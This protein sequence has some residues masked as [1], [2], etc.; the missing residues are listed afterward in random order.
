MSFAG[1]RKS[2]DLFARIQNSA[3]SR[4]LSR[5]IS[6]TATL[7]SPAS[8]NDNSGDDCPD[9]GRDT[10][11]YC[12]HY[13]R[14]GT[15]AY[16]QQG[17]RSSHN[18]PQPD[19]FMLWRKLGFS[20]IPGWVR[21]RSSQEQTHI[22][23]LRRLTSRGNPLPE[24]GKK[25]YCSFYLQ[26][27]HC[28]YERQ[29]CKFSHQVPDQ[30]DL[31]LWQAIGFTRIPGWLRSGV[32]ERWD[33]RSAGRV[34]GNNDGWGERQPPRGPGSQQMDIS[35]PPMRRTSHK[36]N[37]YEPSKQDEF[38][39]DTALDSFRLGEQT[40]IAK[41]SGVSSK[42]RL[43]ARFVA[44]GLSGEIRYIEEKKPPP[45]I[46]GVYIYDGGC[47]QHLGT[48]VPHSSRSLA[49][50]TAA[51]EALRNPLLDVA[52]L[53]KATFDGEFTFKGGVSCLSLADEHDVDASNCSAKQ[54]TLKGEYTVLRAPSDDRKD[55]CGINVRGLASKVL[56]AD[57]P[58][59][60][61][62]Q[63]SNQPPEVIVSTE[64]TKPKTPEVGDLPKAAGF[65]YLAALYP[66]EECMLT[67]GQR[68]T[69]TLSP[70]DGKRTSNT[71][72]SDLTT[73]S[74]SSQLRKKC[75]F[76]KKP[77]SN[78]QSLIPCTTCPRKYHN[79][80]G[81]P[82]P[83]KAAKGSFVC[84]RCIEKQEARTGN[85]GV[86]APSITAHSENTRPNASAT[87]FD[88]STVQQSP[89]S[90]PQFVGIPREG[91]AANIFND[92]ESTKLKTQ[93]TRTDPLATSNVLVMHD[94][95][96]FDG[97][98]ESVE[99]TKQ[100]GPVHVSSASVSKSSGDYRPGSA[101]STGHFNEATIQHALRRD[102]YD[103]QVRK[104]PCS[105][106]SACSTDAQKGLDELAD[107]AQG[108]RPASIDA[109]DMYG[110]R[111]EENGLGQYLCDD[112]M[113]NV[114]DAPRA[115]KAMRDPGP[116]TRNDTDVGEFHDQ[117]M[118]DNDKENM[119]VPASRHGGSTE[120]AAS[121][122]TYN[123]SIF[124]A[125]QK[126][127]RQY[128][129]VTCPWWQAGDTCKRPEDE[130]IFSHRRTGIESPNGNNKAKHWTCPAW[131]SGEGCPWNAEQCL[132]THADTGYYVGLD[133][134]ARKK[135]LTCYWFYHRGWC[136]RR[137]E[138]CLF[139]HRWTGLLAEEP[140]SRPAKIP[141]RRHECSDSWTPA[142]GTFSMPQAATSTAHDNALHWPTQVQSLI[143]MDTLAPTEFSESNS[144]G[145][146]Q[147]TIPTT[148]ETDGMNAQLWTPET[149][150][151]PQA[152]VDPRA[153]NK[154]QTSAYPQR[155]VE[156]EHVALSA[157]NNL[158]IPV[159][160]STS[161]IPI[162][163]PK[164][165]EL[166]PLTSSGVKKCT[167]CGKKVIGR[168][169][170]V[171]CQQPDRG[172]GDESPSITTTRPTNSNRAQIE[173]P[174]LLPDIDIDIQE[175]SGGIE[176]KDVDQVP[177]T[178]S[179]VLKRSASGSGL[180][181]P[182][183]RT[184][185]NVPTVQRKITT[186]NTVPTSIEEVIAAER[187]KKEHHS[188][189]NSMPITSKR[190]S[191]SSGLA[192]PDHAL[193][194]PVK[195]V[196]A[197]ATRSPTFSNT[198]ICTEELAG[199]QV[200]DK[201]RAPPVEETELNSSEIQQSPPFEPHNGDDEDLVEDIEYSVTESMAEE[202][203][204]TGITANCLEGDSSDEESEIPLLQRY[205][206][207]RQIEGTTTGQE[208]LWSSSTITSQGTTAGQPTKT[209][210]SKKL[211]N[212]RFDCPFTC[213]QTFSDSKGATRHAT[214]L[215]VNVINH[216]CQF[217]GKGYC[218]KDKYRAH[219]E[220][221]SV[222]H[223]TRSTQ[224]HYTKTFVVEERKSE[225]SK[226]IPA[227]SQSR[228]PT[229]SRS[230]LHKGAGNDVVQSTFSQH[231]RPVMLTEI[232]REWRDKSKVDESIASTT[233]PSSNRRRIT[234]VEAYTQDKIT[235]RSAMA[236]QMIDSGTDETNS[237]DSGILENQSEQ[238]CKFCL[239][240][241]K[242]GE[243][244]HGAYGRLEGRKCD[245]YISERVARNVQHIPADNLE[246][247]IKIEDA[248]LQSRRAWQ[249]VGTSDRQENAKEDV[250]IIPGTLTLFESGTGMSMDLQR[251]LMIHNHGPG[252][253]VFK[254]QI[255]YGP[256]KQEWEITPN[257]GELE[258]RGML[259]VYV[260]RKINSAPVSHRKPGS[261]PTQYPEYLTISY[262]TLAG[263]GDVSRMKVWEMAEEQ[264][265]VPIETIRVPIEYT[266][267]SSL[268]KSAAGGNMV[269]ASMQDELEYDDGDDRDELTLSE[270]ET[271]KAVKKVRLKPVVQVP[272]RKPAKKLQSQEASKLTLKFPAKIQRMSDLSIQQRSQTQTTS[273]GRTKEPSTTKALE[274]QET[275]TLNEKPSATA[276]VRAV[277]KI[278]LKVGPPPVESP[279]NKSARSGTQHDLIAG[280]AVRAEEL[281]PNKSGE[282][283][284][285]GRVVEAPMTK[286]KISADSPANSEYEMQAENSF[287]PMTRPFHRGTTSG[288]ANQRT[289]SSQKRP[290]DW[291]ESESESMESEEDGLLGHKDVVRPA[292]PIS[293]HAG[294]TDN[295]VDQSKRSLHT[296]RSSTSL[297]ASGEPLTRPQP[298]HAKKPSKSKRKEPSAE[299]HTAIARLK[300]RGVKFEDPDTDDDG[301]DE[302]IDPPPPKPQ[303]ISS[304]TYPPR[305]PLRSFLFTR[306]KHS[307][308][309]KPENS[310]LPAPPEASLPLPKI[311]KGQGMKQPNLI[312]RRQM[313]RNLW[314]HGNAH[315]ECDRQLPKQ[316]VQAMVERKMADSD[317]RFAPDVLQVKEEQITFREFCGLKRDAEYEPCLIGSG[318]GARL[319]FREKEDGK[320]GI[321]RRKRVA[322]GDKWPV[323]ER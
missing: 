162:S 65:N 166:R 257:W 320:L 214:D 294:V 67:T 190:S 272:P 144:Q 48:G 217:C 12:R 168:D 172:L 250:T 210:A 102:T 28:A 99:L 151:R 283:A 230:S 90:P 92:A 198:T 76:C 4:K 31:E 312:R 305:E 301:A 317:D 142:S 47:K 277:K 27:G 13:L 6:T 292:K 134:K 243:C 197:S 101:H 293:R 38:S 163:R 58:R 9:E 309:Y 73:S 133:G 21:L 68:K 135:H 276:R 308:Y 233:T 218:R 274:T 41:F 45:F 80:C 3:D 117:S 284:T 103:V 19:D 60:G 297:R 83:D 231:L 86:V 145:P 227:A 247:L 110:E 235:N 32:S 307:L 78:F 232:P 61:E 263:N 108:Q 124:A 211:P 158:L 23:P 157:T 226:E 165:S 240:S 252:R 234:G 167:S 44:S 91:S 82:R 228:Q 300:A 275:V 100:P 125:A 94:H 112:D 287:N 20:N 87:S 137:R 169:V 15:C 173:L 30:D 126:V 149:Q 64:V 318:E 310:L 203:R 183:K 186:P 213:G 279:M 131:M 88:V 261:L 36:V 191:I 153:R 322:D 269:N 116:R 120:F 260:R 313:L 245:D 180:F 39:K 139:A 25:F 176:S 138:V 298:T 248:A 285:F 221:C 155:P 49:E 33:R 184:R 174:E 193:D 291:A 42:Q 244:L 132:Y 303:S 8:P 11:D 136:N 282:A 18:V 62:A 107:S 119:P 93:D 222:K 77:E 170:C 26:K 129:N 85:K 202:S 185:P 35:P 288:S 177:R 278:N 109:V 53:R 311:T 290:R 96:L 43:Q 268:P 236:T 22:S 141:S 24:P 152:S 71:P 237:D 208:K 178:T 122:L 209:P 40:G 207:N 187:A 54:N 266:R 105:K 63:G 106:P 56:K 95:G 66:S 17:C 254:A 128:K 57:K 161:E 46:V 146:V 316:E 246:Q 264:R 1:H 265:E 175:T 150:H 171:S 204:S 255:H 306:D 241:A 304:Q 229:R 179:K 51:E 84:G 74:R 224:Y 258:C 215:H 273:V 223:D 299:L 205:Q 238:V 216:Q 113:G 315:K 220:S 267:K 89:A 206:H 118:F 143:R 212:G 5:P 188:T 114:L 289:K 256:C 59:S 164:E 249:V 156:D 253:I 55:T 7:E 314:L 239:R 79:I 81:D 159:P 189:V 262:M 225:R 242:V 121:H 199:K 194:H 270:V 271:P 181:A 160:N 34:D 123:A 37:G 192:S 97:Q 321:G 281:L 296:A 140:A 50:E 182:N 130:C 75:S 72:L 69:R 201:T 195:S 127:A 295:I 148:R 200:V 302:D 70:H 147:Y 16:T 154:N 196:S 104:C 115:P 280:K 319:A 10:I 219:I 98:M 2:L 111:Q 259:G 52:V 323:S 251:L 14:T 286:Q 29:G